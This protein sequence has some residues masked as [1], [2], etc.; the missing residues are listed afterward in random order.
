MTTS[1]F[2]TL[3]RILLATGGLCLCVGASAAN[4]PIYKWTDQNGV[5]NYSNKT[6]PQTRRAEQISHDRLSVISMYK[7]SPD[8]VRALNQRLENRRINALEDELAQSRALAE[9]RYQPAEEQQIGYYPG[10]GYLPDFESR[11]YRGSVG[12]RPFMHSS[13]RHGHSH[14]SIHRSR[15]GSAP[16]SDHIGGAHAFHGGNHAAKAGH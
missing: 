1:R 10:G 4:V 9:A 14:H 11:Y 12:G 16:I 13:R 3:C 7:V 2:H 8:E 6:P 5:V 15:P